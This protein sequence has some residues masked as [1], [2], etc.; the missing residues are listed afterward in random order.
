M[1][2]FYYLLFSGL[3]FFIFLLPAEVYAGQN[4]RIEHSSENVLNDTSI[5]L[6]DTIFV[7][8]PTGKRKTDRKNI[9][10]A[11]DAVQPGGVVQFG[12]GIYLLGAGA[13]LTVP[14]V[15]VLGHPEGTIIKGCNSDAF[16]VEESQIGS[17]VFGCT[18]FYIQAERQTIRGLTFE[19]IWHAIV[20]GA[21][22]TTEEEAST[23]WSSE[24]NPAIYP[25]GWQLIEKNTFRSVVNGLRMLGTGDELSVVR[26][27]KFIDVF[28]AIGIY[29]GPLHFLGNRIT[30]ANP[31]SVPLCCHPGSAILVSPGPTD[32][33][34]YVVAENV[35]KGY[36]DPIYVNS[37]PGSV[38]LVEDY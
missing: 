7:A 2:T 26:N 18:G 21:Y 19:Y 27:N 10:T 30:V 22:P 36:P 25:A 4:S 33:S 35:I 31:E 6:S 37:E 3:L 16:E 9:Q 15:T 1:R 34:G 8:L 14:D 5:R 28:H 11:F 17:V 23:F 13:R 20:V 12:Q 29:G 32:C 24:K 38:I